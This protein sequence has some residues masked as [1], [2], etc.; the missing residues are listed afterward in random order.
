MTIKTTS[1]KTVILFVKQIASLS[2]FRHAVPL[3]ITGG[4]HCQVSSILTKTDCINNNKNEQ[5][6][7]VKSN[8]DMI[9]DLS[10]VFR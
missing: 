2:H 10:P 5:I 6:I 4:G 3:F 7:A 9:L 8:F 1:N